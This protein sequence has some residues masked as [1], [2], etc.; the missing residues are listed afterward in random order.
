MHAGWY[1]KIAIHS[2]MECSAARLPGVCV[3]MCCMEGGKIEEA[4]SMKSPLGLALSAR[5]S[6]RTAS[7]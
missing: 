6:C 4:L 5:S 2:N 3:H 7:Q 1:A